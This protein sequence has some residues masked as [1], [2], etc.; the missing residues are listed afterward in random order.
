MAYRGW[1]WML[2]HRALIR[3]DPFS[4]TFAGKPWQVHEWLSE[5][6]MALAYRLSGWS[7]VVLLAG[8]AFAATAGLLLWHLGRF[9]PAARK[10]WSRFLPLLAASGSLLARPHLLALPVLTFWTIALLRR[11]TRGERPPYG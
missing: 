3:A 11:A 1:V 10:A 9:L 6:L 8:C 7:G 5:I 4:F 2:D